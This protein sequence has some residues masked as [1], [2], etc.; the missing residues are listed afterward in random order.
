VSNPDSAVTGGASAAV[1]VVA[2][3]SAVPPIP[4]AAAVRTTSR[5][6]RGECGFIVDVLM[7]LGE[8]HCEKETRLG[9]ATHLVSF[10]VKLSKLVWASAFDHNPTLPDLV[11]V[12]SFTSSCFSPLKKHSILSPIILMESVCHSPDEI[13][14]SAFWKSGPR[15]PPT[16]F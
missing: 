1:A 9:T 13:L 12:S 3:V 4:S 15:L 14:T 6:E 8:G 7:G 2:K 10:D 5:R 11:D 16:T